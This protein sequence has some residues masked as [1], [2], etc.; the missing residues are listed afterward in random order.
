M[1][2]A[3]RLLAALPS[4]RGGLRAILA[5]LTAFGIVLA[6]AG[7]AAMPL[8]NEG[9]AVED[10]ENSSA[11]HPA[12]RMVYPEGQSA[13]EYV[14]P[15]YETKY[16]VESILSDWCSTAREVLEDPTITLNVVEGKTV[17]PYLLPGIKAELE[18]PAPDNGEQDVFIPTDYLVK[19]MREV[20]GD[21]G[22]EVGTKVF[23]LTYTS[24]TVSATTGLFSFVKQDPDIINPPAPEPTPE[25]AP[26]PTAEPTSEPS[27]APVPEPTAAPTAEPTPQATAEPS[28]TPSASPTPEPAPTPSPTPSAAP[29][30]SASPST[31]ASPSSSPSPSQ[32][33]KPEPTASAQPSAS[34]S[35]TAKT[36]QDKPAVQVLSSDGSDLQGEE[37]AY[38]PD[39]AVKVRGTGWCSQGTMLD[40]EKPVEIKVAAYGGYVVPGT[41][42]VPV[43]FQHG[44]FEAQLNLSALYTGG[45]VD[46]GRY[47]LQLSVIDSGL[48]AATNIFA[49]NKA[50]TPQPKPEP[51]P[52]P[53]TTGPDQNAQRPNP[54]GG[55]RPGTDNA[56]GNNPGGGTGSGAGS[57]S[58]AGAGGQNDS[59]EQQTTD[60]G[61]DSRSS[62]SQDGSARQQT[63]TDAVPAPNAG[64][65][66]AEGAHAPEDSAA[67]AQDSPEADAASQRTTRPD[68][69]PVA[70]VTS[71]AHLSAD[72]AGS[73]SGSRQGNI[74]NL[75]LPKSKVQAGEWVS[76]FVFPGAT[77]KGWVQVDDANS[78]SIDI[79][80][81]NSG[82]YE[83]AVADRDNSLLGWAKLEISSASFDP[84]NP[85]QAQL[86]TF[87]DTAAAPTKGLSAN[88]MLLGTAGGLLVVGAVSLLVAAFSGMPLRAPRTTQQLRLPRRH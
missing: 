85:A 54:N 10:T 27:A 84:R 45:N 61:S 1:Q 63:D 21:S 66:G 67:S 9:K 55:G 82:S 38:D 24:G 31:T 33:P 78:V 39:T 87:P 37:P 35:A 6:T 30:P 19:G 25:P 40:G 43:T 68:R 62:T 4:T 32:S 34:P 56:P 81:F 29:S 83:L 64:D 88:D 8:L 86:L 26:E 57:G 60:A 77:T 42:S 70:P 28:A 71:A 51:S 52:A 41:L 53:H 73:L 36:C 15:V 80:T 76:V 47:Y 12:A 18:R 50:V 49:L 23:S 20:T 46:K 2:Y 72:N 79:S 69:S 65:S 17:T 44:S 3:Q 7:V 48:T 11:C 14:V 74:V 59:S 58:G 5:V 16:G 22:W 75:V 13:P